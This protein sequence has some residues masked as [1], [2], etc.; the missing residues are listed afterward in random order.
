MNDFTMKNFLVLLF[1]LCSLSGFS[2]KVAVKNNL[3]YDA[4]KT[5]NLSFEF[6]LGRKLTF[7]TQVG[8]NFFF[9]SKDATSPHYKTKKISHWLVQPELRY[10]TCDVFNGWFFGLHALGGQMNVGGINIPFVLHN[11][12]KHMGNHRYE[13][14]YFGG[15][16]SAGYQWVLSSRFNLEAELGFGYAHAK[17]D[18]YKCTTCGKK[19]GTGHGDY[20]GPTKAAISIIYMLK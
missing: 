17:F 4:A 9:Y 1:L 6:A 10:W 3:V 11:G 8:M 12:D 13:G 20:I 2:Q 5:P 16:L 7:D 14:Y 15:G 18:K 19:L